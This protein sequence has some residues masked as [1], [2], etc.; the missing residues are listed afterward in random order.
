MWYTKGINACLKDLDTDGKNGLMEEEAAERQKKYG[1]NSIDDSGKKEG[2]IKKLLRQLNDF[3][4]IIL[5]ELL[6]K[7]F[8]STFGIIGFTTYLI[9]FYEMFVGITQLCSSG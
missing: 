9:G 8:A 7:P 6:A 1:S 2:I 5:I 4:V 3:L